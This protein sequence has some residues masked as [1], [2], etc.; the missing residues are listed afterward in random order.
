MRRLQEV[1][2]TGDSLFRN[3]HVFYREALKA[4]PQ[5]DSLTIS[6]LHY[7]QQAFAEFEANY[8]SDDVVSLCGWSKMMLGTTSTNAMMGPALLRDNPDLLPSVW[9]VERGFFFFINRIPRTFAG[10]YFR[11]RDRVLAAFTN[12][13]SNEENKEGSAPMMWDREVQLRAKGMTTKDVAAYS[14]SAYAVSNFHCTRY[15]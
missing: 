6:F 4:G 8:A 15:N 3:A 7:L 11:A 9:L 13:F 12:Y 5:L 10:K 2:E 1:D 14:Y